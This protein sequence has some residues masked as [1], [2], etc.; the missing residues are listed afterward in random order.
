[1]LHNYV[2]SD[3]A[4]TSVCAEVFVATTSGSQVV[5]NDPLLGTYHKVFKL[6]IMS[7][8]FCNGCGELGASGEKEAADFYEVCKKEHHTTLKAQIYSLQC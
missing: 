6:L 5:A 4:V 8:F 1:L 2:A 7:T 3:I